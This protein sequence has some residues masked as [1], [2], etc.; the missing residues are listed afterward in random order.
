MRQNLDETLHDL[1]E[2]LENVQDLDESQIE[3]LRN[4]VAEIKATL[5]HQHVSSAG[6]AEQLEEATQ[7]FSSSHPV[8]TNTI[9]RMADLLSQMGI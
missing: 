4:A 9:G 3:M 2:Q 5:D 7:K 6:L 1:H 8:L